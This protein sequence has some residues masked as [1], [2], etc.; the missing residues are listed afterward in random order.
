MDLSFFANNGKGMAGAMPN[1]MGSQQQMM[2]QMMMGGSSIPG[3]G[4]TSNRRLQRFNGSSASNSISG[5][6]V[7]EAAEPPTRG[8]VDL[9]RG[10]DIVQDSPPRKSRASKQRDMLG[11]FDVIEDSEVA[12]ASDDFLSG[13]DVVENSPT[14]RM[15]AKASLLK[16]FDIVEDSE[17]ETPA[18][19][20]EKAARAK[21]RKAAKEKERAEH[22]AKKAVEQ[23]AIAAE[24]E[25]KRQAK[26]AEKNLRKEKQAK[27][28]SA[29]MEARKK[30]EEAAKKE[31]QEKLK[32]EQEKK[33]AKEAERKA[34]E[35][36]KARHLKEKK[37]RE[38]EEMREYREQM[39]KIKK[40]KEEA[41][42]KVEAEK[43][44][45][46][47]EQRLAL[48]AQKEAAR[49]ERN[50]RMEQAKG[51][52]NEKMLEKQ[53]RAEEKATKVAK[54]KLK[55]E[56]EAQVQKEKR[57]KNTKEMQL[58]MK[59]AKKRYDKHRIDQAIASISPKRN[60][61]P[62]FEPK[63][64][65]A[66]NKAENSVP[67]LKKSE[68]PAKKNRKKGKKSKRKKR[69]ES[70]PVP[71]PPPQ[72]Y[73]P[74]KPGPYV[75]KSTEDLLAETMNEEK[76]DVVDQELEEMRIKRRD[77]A[78]RRMNQ[79]SLL[80]DMEKEHMKKTKIEN[81]RRSQEKIVMGRVKREKRILEEQVA[82]KIAQKKK[83]HSRTLVAKIILDYKN[84]V[85]KWPDC[86]REVLCLGM[87]D[88]PQWV[89]AREEHDQEAE[90]TFA[91]YMTEKEDEV[92][93]RQSVETQSM[94]IL[95][96]SQELHKDAVAASFQQFKQAATVKQILSMFAN[97]Y[98]SVVSPDGELIQVDIKPQR[99]TVGCRA[100]KHFEC[101]ANDGRW[102]HVGL[103]MCKIAEQFAKKSQVTSNILRMSSEASVRVSQ[104]KRSAK[105]QDHTVI[106]D[107]NFFCEILA[108]EWINWTKTCGRYF[109]DV[110]LSEENAKLMQMYKEDGTLITVADRL[111]FSRRRVERQM[112]RT[113]QGYEKLNYV[114]S[115]ISETERAANK[116]YHL[117]C[118]KVW[119]QMQQGNVPRHVLE[120]YRAEYGENSDISPVKRLKMYADED[121]ERKRIALEKVKKEEKEESENKFIAWSKNKDKLQ[122]RVS[123]DLGAS[124]AHGPIP[125]QYTGQGHTP[126]DR[127]S[128]Q[129][130]SQYM[131]AGNRTSMPP[132]NS[133]MQAVVSGRERFWARKSQNQWNEWEDLENSKRFLKR[134]VKLKREEKEYEKERLEM[135]EEEFSNFVQS[136]K[137]IDQAKNYLR[138][139]SNDR[140]YNEGMW[141]N[142]A[143][144]M[145]AI[146]P[147]LST[148]WLEWSLEHRE[149][150]PLPGSVT[151]AKGSKFA[152]TTADWTRLLWRG[153]KIQVDGHEE[154][155][156]AHTGTFSAAE[157]P[158]QKAPLRS[159][160]G[161]S[162]TLVG[163]CS[164]DSCLTIW[165]K[166]S[167][168]FSSPMMSE[169]KLERIARARRFVKAEFQRSKALRAAQDDVL[170]EAALK[171]SRHVQEELK[172][173]TKVDEIQFM[174][175]DGFEDFFYVPKLDE[176]GAPLDENFQANSLILSKE[177]YTIQSVHVGDCLKL[178]DTAVEWWE[179]MSIDIIKQAVQIRR[180]HRVKS[181]GLGRG[182]LRIAQRE[183]QHL[184]MLEIKEGREIPEWISFQ[185]LEKKKVY[186]RR[187]VPQ[188]VT[189][190]SNDG[191]NW[192]D[193]REDVELRF[194]FD[195]L[196]P[197]TALQELELYVREDCT[198][199]KENE[200][201]E[202]VRSWH[203]ARSWLQVQIKEKEDFVKNNLPRLHIERCNDYRSWLRVGKSMYDFEQSLQTF[204]RHAEEL[205]SE[206][207]EDARSHEKSDT[208][209][210]FGEKEIF[211]LRKAFS[212]YDQRG[213]GRIT[214]RELQAALSELK[215]EF[216]PSDAMDWIREQKASKGDGTVGFGEFFEWVSNNSRHYRVKDAWVDDGQTTP[217][218]EKRKANEAWPNLERHIDMASGGSQG[219]KLLH[220]WTVWTSQSDK[221]KMMEENGFSL[222]E[223]H[224]LCAE[225]WGRFDR[226]R[227]QKE[228]MVE[229][230]VEND[231]MGSVG[232]ENLPKALAMFDLPA[233]KGASIAS[234]KMEEERMKQLDPMTAWSVRSYA[235]LM[236]LDSICKRLGR[237]KEEDEKKMLREQRR[238]LIP[239]QLNVETVQQSHAEIIWGAKGWHGGD[240]YS[241]ELNVR[242]LP[243]EVEGSGGL[244]FRR[245]KPVFSGV[246]RAC[247]VD[248]LKPCTQYQCRLKI[249]TD[250]G[251][252]KWSNPTSFVTLPANPENVRV[253]KKMYV[254]N[255]KGIAFLK[256]ST[257][258][259]KKREKG[260]VV[261]VKGL[262]TKS[263]GNGGWT[264][265]YKGKLAQ[266]SINDVPLG[267]SITCRVCAFNKAK[268]KGPWSGTVT[269]TLKKSA[270]REKAHKMTTRTAPKRTKENFGAH[271]KK[272]D[273]VTASPEKPLL[274]PA[275]D[276]VERWDSASGH[277]YYTSKSTKQVTMELPKD[278]RFTSP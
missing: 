204:R 138:Q 112:V 28:R 243:A 132:T 190:G 209:R 107:S 268:K 260:Y 232:R 53:R 218:P 176:F 11:S 272:L 130:P 37:D 118:L 276:W 12:P 250:K 121:V 48:E 270:K 172:E 133:A 146:S 23:A 216:D 57:E 7:I 15:R 72:S 198:K 266:C 126:K 76:E 70:P 39:R 164:K 211:L 166:L 17:I 163:S 20:D 165:S 184:Y 158:L 236:T 214:F 16:D 47:E 238:R 248:R 245:Y 183:E 145:L 38:D 63:F 62:T 86:Y 171:N 181:I 150:T 85:K 90:E 225:E 200:E 196:D 92:L 275:N 114:I 187:M 27:L 43:Q 117:E 54:A 109:E 178:D 185:S 100:L 188:K 40:L 44:R 41:R 13:F 233:A 80:K 140:A 159:A 173:I 50:L 136:A 4:S 123:K 175:S 265:V 66:R 234:K 83:E 253:V 14:R 97:L 210:T 59:E 84:K 156:V 119:N 96:Q 82:E 87:Y 51:R 77:A 3:M 60:A 131:T 256:W 93:L 1:N 168:R 153:N 95:R 36:E 98:E 235:L 18:V 35:A 254:G 194:Q 202:R 252:K 5:F 274:K 89:D 108:N 262:G 228:G 222:H 139:L 2:M 19:S 180:S 231:D 197:V 230:M 49:K 33:A 255:T 46:R 142:V 113:T 106:R 102:W 278:Q 137:R 174:N 212:W 203:A 147:S 135:A 205:L 206:I 22:E 56:K 155:I 105:D 220:T 103:T 101:R 64:S 246:D 134:L 217:D 219:R 111:A 221:W 94:K 116:V 8:A 247:I 189:D 239:R 120:S 251:I 71:P 240:G 267:R 227:F 67:T 199:R 110:Q 143:R 186:V 127:A 58:R 182:L 241:Y 21:K 73:A 25:K 157:V 160:R 10:F 257:G 213:E 149:K 226:Y 261:E 273:T 34:R 179:V 170:A 144:C 65:P 277:T 104:R 128:S 269:T 152:Q 249:T 124:L 167:R 6:D 81:L 24:K 162:A 207:G 9:L 244:D 99:D 259:N 223:M 169:E 74:G 161:V 88:D 271:L 208:V 45:K 192:E 193:E 237:W 151:I 125:F 263:A 68:S 191:E 264:C 115:S 91:G 229:D 154:L 79:R 30:R 61:I 129:L 31:K 32:K 52:Y 242:S 75:K 258:G 148:N 215:C 78:L 26:I 224:A 122:L 55:K 201:K 141:K 29:E 177:N 195:R 69:D 42:Q